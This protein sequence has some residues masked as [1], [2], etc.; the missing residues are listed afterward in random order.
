MVVQA[1]DLILCFFLPHLYDSTNHLQQVTSD[2]VEE[3][4]M[5][6]NDLTQDFSSDFKELAEVLMA[7]EFLE[8]AHDASNGLELYMFLLG[9]ITVFS[10]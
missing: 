8:I 5:A 2:E 1:V 4:D 10:E 3:F 9:K 6:I 7:Q